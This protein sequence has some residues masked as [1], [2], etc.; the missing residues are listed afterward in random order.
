[1]GEE[2]N[3]WESELRRKLLVK[4]RQGTVT[5]DRVPTLHTAASRLLVTN[6][7]KADL[8]T[9]HFSS[10]MASDEPERQPPASPA[11]AL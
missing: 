3:R 11:C 4:Q 5:Q 9:A 1:M 10:K 8:F 7:A 2:R 6:Q